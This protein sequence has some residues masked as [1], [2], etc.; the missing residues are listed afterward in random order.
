MMEL[1]QVE[2]NTLQAVGYDENR[3]ILEVLLISGKTYH[4]LEVPKQIYEQ[5][6]AAGSKSGYMENSVIDSYRQRQV[7]KRSKVEI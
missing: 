7:R 3:Q 1:Q 5:L 2:S 4:Y 6:L